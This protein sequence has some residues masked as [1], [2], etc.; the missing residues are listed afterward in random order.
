MDT[1]TNKQ[2]AHELIDLVPSDQMIAALRFLEFLG[3]GR[4]AATT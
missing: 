1:L 3:R 2:P 4:A